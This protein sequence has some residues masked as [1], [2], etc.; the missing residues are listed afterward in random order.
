M[1][2]RAILIDMLDTAEIQ[3]FKQ[4]YKAETIIIFIFLCKE[5]MT[6]ISNLSKAI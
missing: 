4:P 5:S 1:I 2:L 3:I 6:Q